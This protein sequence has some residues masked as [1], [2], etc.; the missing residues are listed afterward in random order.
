MRWSNALWKNT[1]HRVSEPPQWKG[2]GSK[3]NDAVEGSCDSG[4]AV[5]ERYSIACF[6]APDP[7]T[8]V[9]ALPGCCENQAPRWKPINAGE[10]LH[11][12]IAAMYA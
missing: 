8:V 5:P 11:R 6:G 9:E 3:I 2:R 12:K 1:V 10:Y 4:E 7:T